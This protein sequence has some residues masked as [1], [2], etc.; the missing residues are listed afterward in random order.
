MRSNQRTVQLH[1]LPRTRLT[2]QTQFLANVRYESPVK[3]TKTVLVPG[4]ARACHGQRRCIWS[5]RENHQQRLC[6]STS[7]SDSM[8][9][10][11][12]KCGRATHLEMRQKERFVWL[13]SNICRVDFALGHHRLQCRSA[14]QRASTKRMAVFP[15]RIQP[16]GLGHE[17]NKRRAANEATS[18]A[19]HTPPA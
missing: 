2:E 19:A 6:N 15:W 8:C 14:M 10:A 13:R 17:Q 16:A 5:R 3:P 11:V 1:T 12:I 9:N 4:T 7:Y 18:L